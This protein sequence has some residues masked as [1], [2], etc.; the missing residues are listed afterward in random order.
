MGTID[1]MAPE[2]A[3]DTS[4][5]D[6][7]ADIYGLGCTLYFLLT[8]KRMYDGSTI[9]KRLLAHREGAI[10]SLRAVRPERRPAWMPSIKRWSPSCRPIAFRR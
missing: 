6:H 9:M 3:L 2:Q 10:P 8:G 7:R 1:Y 4:G 5:A